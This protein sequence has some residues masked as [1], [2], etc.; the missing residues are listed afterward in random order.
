MGIRV[1]IA[2]DHELIRQGLR[3]I[4]HEAMPSAGIG[5][6]RTAAEA[7]LAARAEAWDLVILDINLADNSGLEVLK[8]IKAREP[9]LPVLILSMYPEAQFA[10]RAMRA[11]ASGYLNKNQAS[12]ELVAAIQTVLR[13]GQYISTEVAQEL[14]LAVKHPSDRPLHAG[15]SDREDQIFR[16]LAS[17]RTVGEIG[18][19]LTISVKTVSS[20]RARILDKLRLRN[21]AELMRYAREHSLGD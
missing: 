4:L 9:C 14:L 20:H 3:R 5:E 10:L 6:A 16:L 13:G 2:D 1:L 15:L 8:H 18:Q 7:V 11:G 19:L 17:G 21:N 12:A